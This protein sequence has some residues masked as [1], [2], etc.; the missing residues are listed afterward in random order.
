M[1]YEPTFLNNCSKDST[2]YVSGKTMRMFC[3]SIFLLLVSVILASAV[4]VQ[5]FEVHDRHSR[6]KRQFGFG[7]PFGYGRPYGPGFG[8]PLYGGFGRP[9]GLY[10]R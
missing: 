6:Q 1:V 2:E 10:G 8:R 5:K 7:R 9:Y 3:V 4:A